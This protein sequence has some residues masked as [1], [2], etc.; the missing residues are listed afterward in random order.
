MKLTVIVILNDPGGVTVCPVNDG[1]SSVKRERHPGWILMRR[2]KVDSSGRFG[3]RIKCV[4]GYAFFIKRNRDRVQSGS[5]KR[6]V[7]P[8]IGGIFNDNTLPVVQQHV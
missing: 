4:N 5:L 1:Q 7:C 3:Q 2:R 8:L 6:F